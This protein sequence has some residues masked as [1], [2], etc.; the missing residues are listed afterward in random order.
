MNGI[1]LSLIIKEL[2]D[3]IQN[4]FINRVLIK[5]RLIQLEFDDNA[6]F[7]SLFPQA[8][9]IFI[10]RIKKDFEKMQYFDD[11]ISGSRIITLNQV[12]YA[13]LLEIIT[14]KTEY[15]QKKNLMI[16]LSFYKEAPNFSLV[17]DGY[18]RSLFRRVIEKREKRS[19]FEIR[20]EDL[21]DKGL[22]IKNFEGMDSYLA[23]EL[24]KTNLEHLKS[25]LSGGPAMP[26]IVSFLPLR[27]SL[28]AENYI[29]EYKSWNDLMIEGI[30]GYLIEKERVVKE[31]KKRKF[32]EKLRKKIEELEEEMVDISEIE[33]YRIYGELILSNI[34]KI[35]RGL[36]SI[37]LFDHYSQKDIEIKLD[38]KKNAQ[39]N[40]Q[41]YFKKY[42]KKKRGIP[43]LKEKIAEL[44]TKLK[45]IEEGVAQEEIVAPGKKTK[46]IVE[47]RLLPFREF[48]LD[49]GSKV[50]V[51][52][53][54]RSNME[55]TFKFARP[56]DYFFHV[57]GIEGA[58]TILRPQLKRGENP[59]KEDIEIAA[60]IAAYFSKARNQKNV[61]VSYAQRK[62]LKKSKKGK[63]GSVILMRE[64]VI[65]V[66]PGLPRG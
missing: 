43:I 21:K 45:E 29:K 36:E 7:I 56:D 57:R 37:R 64:K 49:S 47:E 63:I 12:S 32:M 58:H 22:L 5:E 8:L 39:E 15:G 6:L 2:K 61:P 20:E 34:L 51:G 10:D 11:Q 59:K 18:E 48:L 38:P 40:A 50:Y 41:E 24:D 46:R 62:Y 3:S 53:S 26:R 54:A 1:Y 44:K 52:K 14:E 16:R 60:A 33:S 19:I 66:D 35:K 17:Y 31:A 27:I 4:Q 65:F 9:G 23:Q 28:F 42:K 30:N 55:L 13:P 25:I